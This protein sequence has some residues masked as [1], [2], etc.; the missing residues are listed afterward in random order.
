MGLV[1]ELVD[2]L[3]DLPKPLAESRARVKK[4]LA[5]L[6]FAADEEVGD[7]FRLLTSQQ[8]EDKGGLLTRE[9][10]A[11][12]A[13]LIT[14]PGMPCRLDLSAIMPWLRQCL[15]FDAVC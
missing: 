11:V 10:N 8:L 2:S 6:G 14:A 4:A 7:A 13:A 15:G 5:K 9:A 12:L 3:T 1:G